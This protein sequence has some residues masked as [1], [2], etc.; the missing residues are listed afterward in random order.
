[1]QPTGDHLRILWVL[2]RALGR[3]EVRGL[4][5]KHGIPSTTIYQGTNPEGGN[6]SLSVLCRIVNALGYELVAR[7]KRSGGAPKNGFPRALP[8]EAKRQLDALVAAAGA[9]S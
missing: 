6:P 8:P 1:M 4:C 7:P 5:K 2:R 9:R 3:H